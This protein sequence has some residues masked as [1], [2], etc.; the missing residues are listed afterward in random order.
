MA[1]D[2]MDFN[3]FGEFVSFCKTVDTVEWTEENKF[4]FNKRVNSLID[5]DS[6]F[7]ENYL[8]LKDNLTKKEV[9]HSITQKRKALSL[10]KI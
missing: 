5:K 9:R 3:N 8:R 4:Q 6:D 7:K 2:K 10:Q 1:N